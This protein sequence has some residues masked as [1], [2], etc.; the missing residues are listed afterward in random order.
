MPDSSPSEDTV[1]VDFASTGSSTPIIFDNRL[2]AGGVTLVRCRTRPNSAGARLVSPQTT[3]VVPAGPAFELDWRLPDGDGL[4][5]GIISR[6]RVMLYPAEAPVWKRW[7]GA[8][9]IFVMALAPGFL[10]D[11]RQRVFEPSNGTDLRTSIG[12]EDPVADH[13]LRAAAREL[14]AGGAH[15]RLFVE[16]VATSLA[17]HLLQRYDASKPLPRRSGGLDVAQ[18][19]RVIDHIEAHLAGD[20][21]LSELASITGLSPDH[22]GDA[23]K[24]ATGLAPYQYVIDRRVAR[25]ADLLRDP[26]L[27]VVQVALAVGFSSQSHLT[28]QFQRVMGVTPARFRR[29][30][31]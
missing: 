22:F 6:G 24:A 28:T 12:V 4:E 27:M 18:L 1:L 8:P 5:S 16:S 25:A 31:R 26:G 2:Q 29:S 23:F 17:V 9:S 13:L 3:I 21:G 19:R 14:N 7:H 10:G 15:G 11:I 20:L 30:L